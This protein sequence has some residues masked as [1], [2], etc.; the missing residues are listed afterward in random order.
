[1]TGFWESILPNYLSAVAAL[2]A[3]IGAICQLRKVRKSTDQLFRGLAQ[4]WSIQTD[5]DE[6]KLQKEDRERKQAFSDC[7]KDVLNLLEKHPNLPEEEIC[8]ELSSKHRESTVSSVLAILKT[9]GSVPRL[10][11][12]NDGVP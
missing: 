8:K 5:M 7:I 6:P 3:A 1:M 9:E 12:R 11:R 10:Q 2:I 4:S